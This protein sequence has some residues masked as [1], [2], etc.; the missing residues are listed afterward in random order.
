[1][2]NKP[3]QIYVGTHHYVCMYVSQVLTRRAAYEDGEA[4]G[5]HNFK[6]LADAV[7]EQSAVEGQ[8]LLCNTT[9]I[10]TYIYTYNIWQ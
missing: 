1:M 4:F 2:L 5:V 6:S 7:K 9:Y 3:L 8:I 10:H